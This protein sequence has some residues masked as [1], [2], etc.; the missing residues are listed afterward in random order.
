MNRS[1]VGEAACEFNAKREVPR[2]LTRKPRLRPAQ[3][4]KG[5][6]VGEIISELLGGFIRAASPGIG[7]SG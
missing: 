2:I 1:R 4:A 5:G 3:L 7:D 6:A